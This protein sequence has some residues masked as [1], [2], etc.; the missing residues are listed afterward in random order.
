MTKK[1]RLE[2]EKMLLNKFIMSGK[3][4]FSAEAA[5]APLLKKV[6]E[7]A[8]S[9]EMD[10]YLNSD[11]RAKGNKRNGKGQKRLKSSFCSFEIDTP[12]DRQSSFVPKLV[13]KRQIILADPFC[14][15]I[16]GLYGLGMSYRDSSSHIKAL[17][18]TGISQNLLTRI[19]DQVMPRVKAWQH[20]PLESLYCIVWLEVMH[21]KIKVGG[22]ITH[23]TRYKILGVTK[24]GTSEVLGIY[25]G[26]R[27]G[28][29]FWEQVLT[30]LKNR[31]LKN[32]LIA[33][34][35]DLEGL[36]EAILSVYPK[37]HVKPGLIHQIRNSL[38]CIASEDHEAFRSDLK[39]IYKAVNQE[40][41]EDQVLN[42]E[43]KWGTKYPEVLESWQLNWEQ[44]FQHIEYTPP[45]R[46]LIYTINE[47]EDFVILPVLGQN[48]SLTL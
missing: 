11:E 6:I 14:E 7:H 16:M 9:A 25:I 35:D 24:E 46:K 20:R 33:C 34:T 13:K 45:I 27:E 22:K 29:R 43:K 12:E 2:F 1:E 32:I 30:D 8:L 21:Y 17:Y 10:F 48:I 3:N 26:E 38:K 47:T 4:L 28:V 37:A 44:L 23:N 18:D 42:L 40:E 31:G 36:T 39:K 15:K 19:V 41:A 5:F